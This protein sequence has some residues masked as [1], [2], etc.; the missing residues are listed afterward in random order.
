MSITRYFTDRPRAGPRLISGTWTITAAMGSRPGLRL[1]PAR[2]H[3]YRPSTVRTTANIPYLGQSHDHGAVGRR[4]VPAP[5]RSRSHFGTGISEQVV[6]AGLSIPTSQLWMNA[7]KR[8][9]WNQ[10]IT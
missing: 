6:I 9:S 7:K 3:A 2:E 8:G 5:D 10:K 1:F 4:A